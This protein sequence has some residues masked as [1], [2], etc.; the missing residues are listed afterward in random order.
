MSPAHLPALTRITFESL[1]PRFKEFLNTIQF[2]CY[3]VPRGWTQTHTH[4]HMN[5]HYLTSSNFYDQL[6]DTAVPE[7]IACPG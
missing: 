3:Q 6:A 7:M 5:T 1:I 4:A 2:L